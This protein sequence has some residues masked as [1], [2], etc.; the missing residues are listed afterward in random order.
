MAAARKARSTPLTDTWKVVA[1][2][3][4]AAEAVST[5]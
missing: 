3:S 5:A 4:L 1:V 2:T